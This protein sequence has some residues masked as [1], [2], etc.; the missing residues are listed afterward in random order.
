MMQRL[1]KTTKDPPSPANALVEHMSAN[2]QFEKWTPHDENLV[3]T[4]TERGNDKCG[5]QDHQDSTL[6]SR[7]SKQAAD[8]TATSKDNNKIVPQDDRSI[9]TNNS[10][11]ATPF[12]NTDSA[13][14]ATYCQEP[15]Q[16]SIMMNHVT[17][18]PMPEQ[19]NLLHLTSKVKDSP[20]HL[21]CTTL[22]P[23]SCPPKDGTVAAAI[24]VVVAALS[25]IDTMK[26]KASTPTVILHRTSEHTMD[27]GDS[28][29]NCSQLLPPNKSTNCT[30]F[31][32]QQSENSEPF[33]SDDDDMFID[34]DLVLS[35]THNYD[36][37]HVDH[38]DETQSLIDI[39]MLPFQN[40]DTV[41]EMSQSEI[42]TWYESQIAARSADEF[43]ML[44]LHDIRLDDLMV[45]DPD[46]G[47]DKLTI[48]L[49]YNWLLPMLTLVTTILLVSYFVMGNQ[50]LI[51]CIEIVPNSVML[52]DLGQ[53][54]LAPLS[55]VGTDFGYIGTVR[56]E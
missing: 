15:L 34:T 40:V 36:H 4:G 23:E 7:V 29:S 20:M 51:D 55:F 45:F 31:D 30:F 28:E 12:L 33:M 41:P 5:I 27:K 44:L 50:F 53:G 47:I 42:A 18:T 21:N 25:P 54:L 39:L 49:W 6:K 43:T 35:N 16:A 10:F 14:F 46:C 11:V 32:C 1:W 9:P 19:N 56:I 37:D 8:I 17:P 38:H 13:T 48:L 3:A 2:A 22:F 26:I 24:D 52:N